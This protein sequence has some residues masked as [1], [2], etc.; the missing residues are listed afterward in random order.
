MQICSFSL[1]KTLIDALDWC[2]LLWCFYQLFGLSFWRHPFTAEDPL[3]SKWCSAKLFQ[4]CLD[5]D[6][7]LWRHSY[8][9]TS[10]SKKIFNLTV[11][12]IQPL[13]CLLVNVKQNKY[14]KT[15]KTEQKQIN[16]T[17][18]VWMSGYND[19]L[20]E[21]IMVQCCDIVTYSHPDVFQPVCRVHRWE[22]VL[23]VDGRIHHLPEF[24]Q[25]FSHHVYVGDLQKVQLHIDIE[26][27]ILISSIFGL[28]KRSTIS[29]SR[30]PGTIA[31]CC[32]LK[33]VYQAAP[34]NDQPMTSQKPTATSLKAGI[35]DVWCLCFKSV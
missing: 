6:F 25:G 24:P 23:L 8:L 20:M 19:H 3:V 17:S 26:T 9:L 22:P 27:L 1:H 11:Q 14:F 15:E 13:D 35:H 16:E 28:Q 4:I 18:R 10:F 21:S 5:E 34:L 30:K 12:Q 31:S 7:L 33:M 2:G 32:W 29:Y